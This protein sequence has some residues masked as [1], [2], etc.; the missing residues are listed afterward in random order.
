MNTSALVDQREVGQV[1]RADVEVDRQLHVLRG[2]HLEADICARSIVVE[3]GGFFKGG[4]QVIARRD[5]P[6]REES[7]SRFPFFMLRPSPSY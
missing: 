4:C 5:E 7:A 6:A 2:G 1:T 3:K